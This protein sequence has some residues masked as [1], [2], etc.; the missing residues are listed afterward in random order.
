MPVKKKRNEK[1]VK[2]EKTQKM[3][4][5]KLV[6]AFFDG[7]LSPRHHQHPI[8][9]NLYRPIFFNML[10]L[11]CNNKMQEKKVYVC[12]TLMV[13]FPCYVIVF[14]FLFSETYFCAILIFTIAM[15]HPY[16]SKSDSTLLLLL[17]YH[18]WNTVRHSR[19]QSTWRTERDWKRN[20]FA[21]SIEH[22]IP[23]AVR[24]EQSISCICS[25]N[26]MHRPTPLLLLTTNLY[27][28]AC[29][30]DSGNDYVYCVYA[31]TNVQV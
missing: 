17:F 10:A 16:Y 18:T 1:K 22:A 29:E 19:R 2:L 4:Y 6:D 30:R 31:T 3:N 24:K 15:M 23:N 13:L 14:C 12:F 7:N 25:L 21:M 20:A 27:Y 11:I 26:C 8:Q 9:E 5:V 28:F